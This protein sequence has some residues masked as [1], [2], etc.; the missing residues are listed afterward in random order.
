MT[1]VTRSVRT[2]VLAIVGLAIGAAVA[3]AQDLEPRAYAA[4]PINMTFVVGAL[5]R[6]S[7]GV[8]TDPSLPIDDVHATLGV[9]MAGIGHTFD[10]FGRSALFIAAMPFARAHA[11]GSVGDVTRE[12]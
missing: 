10:L 2:L 3:G 11:T 6:S 1:R 4:A 9:V 8:V 12:A 5:S 7:G